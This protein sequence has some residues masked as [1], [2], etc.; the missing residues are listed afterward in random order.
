MRAAKSL[1]QLRCKKSEGRRSA[2]RRVGTT[3][4]CPPEEGLPPTL[5]YAPPLM[6]GGVLPEAAAAYP[7]IG[8]KAMLWAT[9]PREVLKGR[10]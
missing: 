5:M 3:Q 6:M 10:R 7:S 1:M 9:P 4:A 8:A 2:Q